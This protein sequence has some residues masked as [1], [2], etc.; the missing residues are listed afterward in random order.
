MTAQPL[1]AFALPPDAEARVPPEERG[2]ARDQVRM[3]VA[4]P[5]RVEHLRVRS[6]P[7]TLHPGDLLVV[8]T[9]ATVPAA[10]PLL[11][12]RYGET[13]HVSTQLDSGEWVVEVRVRGNTG[14]A[15]T[16]PGDVLALPGGLHLTVVDAHPAGQTRLWRAV[17][18][19]PTGTVRY[20]SRHGRPVGYRYLDHP[21]PLSA[22]QTVYAREPGSAEMPSAG[23]PLSLRVLVDLVSRGV[24]VAPVVLHAGVSSQEKLEPPQPELFTVPAVTARLVGSTRSA[25][26][27][28]VA[29]GTTV[30]RA[31]ESAAGRDG[32]VHP[33]TGWTDLVLGPGRPAR[34]V[35]GILTGLHEPRASHLRLLEAV[36]GQSLV[37]RAYDAATADR[38]GYLWHELG[39][40]M[41]LLP[42]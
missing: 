8:N 41:L 21:V 23:R 22:L 10:V 42:R 16:G 28:V 33:T 18:D 39:D 32:S 12:E 19:V 11:G 36:A 26:R 4:R 40:T 34:A 17:P 3:L 14:P 37:Q 27:R 35:D 2:L 24:V 9:S 1:T 5:D 7:E 29:V 13:V 38:V 25:G 15:R 20:L 30:V 6:L 31:L